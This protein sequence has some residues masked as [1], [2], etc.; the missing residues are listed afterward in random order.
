MNEVFSDQ[1]KI[2]NLFRFY[3]SFEDNDIVL[4]FLFGITLVKLL[5]GQ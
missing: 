3:F 4:L 5:D 2:N 1:E